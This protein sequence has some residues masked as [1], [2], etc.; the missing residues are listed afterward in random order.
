MQKSALRILSEMS[1]LATFTSSPL[2]NTYAIPWSM[3]LKAL[4]SILVDVADP[5]FNHG[6]KPAS[7]KA[8]PGLKS[9]VDERPSG[10]FVRLGTSVSWLQKPEWTVS[11]IPLTSAPEYMLKSTSAA[12]RC[13]FLPRRSFSL[14]RG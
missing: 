6:G 9:L 12:S 4:D 13:G 11:T 7:L 14:P 8:F 10:D 1:E 2:F 3:G 5:K